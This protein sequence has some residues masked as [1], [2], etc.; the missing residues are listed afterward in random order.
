MVDGFIPIVLI[1]EDTDYIADIA[2][3]AIQQLGLDT[4]HC[5]TAEAAIEYMEQ[6]LL[7]DVI[8]LDISMPGMNGWEFLEVMKKYEETKTIP[9]IISTVHSDAANRTIGK[10]RDVDRYLIKP[11]LP[12]DLQKTVK[13]ILG[14]ED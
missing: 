6:N 13:V 9:V 2:T 14:I 7:P 12:Q 8:I 1:V 3:R 11:Y 10:L 4:H 5:L